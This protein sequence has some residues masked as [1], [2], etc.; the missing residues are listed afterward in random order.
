LN[1]I[2]LKYWLFWWFPGIA[3]IIYPDPERLFS[4]GAMKMIIRYRVI[5]SGGVIFLYLLPYLILGR[6][7]NI[8]IAD[9]LNNSDIFFLPSLGKNSIFNLAGTIPQKMGGVPGFTV[10]GMW[11]GLAVPFSFADFFSIH[12][13]ND[14]L[15]RAVGFAGIYLL[16]SRHLIKGE[17]NG[18]NFI[19]AGVSLSFALLPFFPGYGLGVAGFPLVSYSFLNIRHDQFKWYDWIIVFAIPFY[20]A[21]FHS[22]LFLS[23]PVCLLIFLDG[24]RERRLNLPLTGALALFCFSGLMTGYGLIRYGVLTPDFLPHR[25]E[26]VGPTHEFRRGMQFAWDHFFNG[27]FA[28]LSLHRPFIITAAAISLFAGMWKRDWKLIAIS[29]GLCLAAGATSFFFGFN[30]WGG[31]Q[32]VRKS[33]F[34]LRTFQFV[35]VISLAPFIWYVVLAVSLK[36]IHRNLNRSD[37]VIALILFQLLF[38]FFLPS[39][40]VVQGSGWRDVGKRWGTN[41]ITPIEPYISYRSYF[42]KELFK[43]IKNYI[44][45][46][47]EEY[48][49]GSLGINPAVTLYNG[50]YT[51]DGFAPVYSLEYKHRFRKIIAKELDKMK[52][53]TRKFDNWGCRVYIR[54]SELLDTT[55]ESR[56]KKDVQISKLELDTDTFREMGGEYILSGV[57][58]ANASENRMIFEKLFLHKDSVWKVYLYRVEDR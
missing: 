18:A 53:R 22:F 58:I 54:S 20:S 43:D 56:W 41:K 40:E 5:I 36:G 15:R 3:R 44:E 28:F 11:W 39:S 38:L 34:I 50:F 29:L 13:F 16:L 45:R 17:D 49:I 23:L 19:T 51:V 57:E 46:P 32:E 14:I 27:D 55:I 47:Q 37:F 12:V 10:F 24:I 25:V 9:Y 8:L 35:R 31:Y 2:N 30:R 4:S 6:D 7:S 33:F 21:F 52:L 1:T 42:S 26:I 48:R